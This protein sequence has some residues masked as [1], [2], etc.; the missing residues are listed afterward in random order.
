M[1]MEVNVDVMIGRDRLAAKKVKFLVE[2]NFLYTI[3]PQSLADKLKLEEN[4]RIAAKRKGKEVKAGFSIAYIE[5]MGRHGFLPVVIL[6]VL[7]PILGASTLNALG[8]KLD[9]ER[10]VQRLKQKFSSRTDFT[11]LAYWTYGNLRKMLESVIFGET[12][13][14]GLFLYK[15]LTTLSADDV[16]IYTWDNK[17]LKHNLKFGKV[18]DHDRAFEL[19]KKLVWLD[20]ILTAS[21]CGLESQ[22]YRDHFLHSFRVMLTTH[23]IAEAL[24]LDEDAIWICTIA[25][26]FHDIAIPL[27]YIKEII[28]IICRNLE[29]CY[30]TVKINFETLDKVFEHKL[31]KR[32]LAKIK[33]ICHLKDLK[34]FELNHGILSAIE[35][36]KL[37]NLKLMTKYQRD[38]I[39]SIIKAI[40]LH[41]ASIGKNF[42]Y[43]ED[44]ASVILILSD[45]L[46]EWNRPAGRKELLKEI[47][48]RFSRDYI[49][50]TID[51]SKVRKTK[52]FSPFY[53][54]SSKQH[55]LDRITF[56]KNFPELRIAFRTPPIKSSVKI[57]NLLQDIEVLLDIYDRL[58]NEKLSGNFHMIP[59]QFRFYFFLAALE[60]L[61]HKVPQDWHIH[62]TDFNEALITSLD[63]VPKE[64]YS[65]LN[66]EKLDWN[67]RVDVLKPKEEIRLKIEPFNPKLQENFTFIEGQ[68]LRIG[69]DVYQIDQHK[70]EEYTF[71]ENRNPAED[72]F[73]LLE[74]IKYAD[75]AMMN[76]LNGFAVGEWGFRID[77][78][79]LAQ[80]QAKLSIHNIDQYVTQL[81]KNDGKILVCIPRY[82]NRVV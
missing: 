73:R 57:L 63:I 40:G 41:D 32:T 70:F 36:L 80:K 71:L 8:L 34:G 7:E 50:A 81:I 5:L 27:S 26:L 68:V 35:F 56:D 28:R 31:D 72:I 42:K 53:L 12:E 52:T 11:L 78:K 47:D 6:D 1:L 14:G 16:L 66:D 10:G 69:D 25:G 30:K 54:I 2:E 29:K 51:F 21:K 64:I 49:A 23:A 55:S 15:V 18:L 60:E 4:C 44:K 37:W 33:D 17:F 48:F 59:P 62:F 65:F 39:Y 9:K 67:I 58:L 61:G 79:D 82:F 45:E 22:F 76:L 24:G 77:V 74:G 75:V 38:I 20:Q 3:I 46:Q 19:C 43:S 13:L